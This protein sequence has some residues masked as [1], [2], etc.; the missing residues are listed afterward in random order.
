MLHLRSILLGGQSTINSKYTCTSYNVV[1]FIKCRTCNKVCI[2]ETGR[3]LGDRFREHLL[4][5]RQTNTDLPVGRHFAS[6]GHAST[7]MLVSVIHSGFRDNQ[8]RRLFED[9]MIIKRKLLHPFRTKYRLCLPMNSQNLLVWM[10]TRVHFKCIHECTFF[11]SARASNFKFKNF[12]FELN[13]MSHRHSLQLVF[14]HRWRGSSLKTYGS[15]S[16][17]SRNNEYLL[18]FL[19][20]Q[21][22]R[23][24]V[25][26]KWN[27]ASLA[28]CKGARITRLMGLICAS[29]ARTN[30]CAHVHN[31][32]D[33]PQA[34]LKNEIN[35]RFLRYEHHKVKL[36]HQHYLQKLY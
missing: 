11:Q 18:S 24:T 31:V 35:A 25:F 9:R 27:F 19:T 12:S 26:F 15:S 7:D 6:P 8:N 34:K 13:V 16:T 3:R 23:N 5:T 21:T 1:Y 10:Y 17:F 30:E 20:E 4:S 36:E 32:R 33:F 29:L 22:F 28:T 2:G 14:I